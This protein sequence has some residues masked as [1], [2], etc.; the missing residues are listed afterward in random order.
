MN[1]NKWARVRARIR[2]IDFATFAKT[3]GATE[4]AL[5]R[6]DADSDAPN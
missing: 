6:D 4:V 5:A 3:L 2:E 1:G